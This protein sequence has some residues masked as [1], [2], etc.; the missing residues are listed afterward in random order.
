MFKKNKIIALIPARGK[1]KGLPGK[2]KKLLFGCPLIAWS[3]IEAKKSKF[4]DRVIVSTDSKEIAKISNRYGAEVPFLRPAKLASDNARV[5]DVALHA[6]RFIER[7][8]KCKYKYL[9]LL[10][11]TSPLRLCS[12]I[13][14]AIDKFFRCNKADALISVSEAYE[15]PFWMQVI[16]KND[17][18]SPLLKQKN[19]QHRR[20][21]LPCVYRI[22]GAIY[23]CK[24]SS[25]S[26]ERT[27]CPKKSIGFLMPKERSIDI[28]DSFDFKLAEFL[29]KNNDKID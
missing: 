24:I 13:D 26:K 9:V 22:N 12:D 17:F 25:L 3:I 14:V 5:A 18:L 21:D 27:F 11:P 2:N 28:D 1:S 29:M 6:I 16:K 4:I 19:E 10:Q 7:Q 23:I 8:D 15:N 20:Q